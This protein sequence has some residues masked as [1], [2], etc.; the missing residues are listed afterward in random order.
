MLYFMKVVKKVKILGEKLEYGYEMI[1]III[2]YSIKS[3][4]VSHESLHN[5]VSH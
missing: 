4:F 5:E 1:M 3:Y 2:I